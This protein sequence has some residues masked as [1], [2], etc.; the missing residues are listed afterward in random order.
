MPATAREVFGCRAGELY[1]PEVSI[2]LGAR[3]LRQLWDRELWRRVEDGP[4]EWTRTRFALAAYNAGPGRVQA[5]WRQ[6]GRPRRWGRLRPQLPGETRIHVHRIMDEFYP[7]YRTSGHHRFTGV[8][9]RLRAGP[10]H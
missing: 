3:Y 7:G 1:R 9:G 5:A 8:A 6:A 2:E 10:G 4:P